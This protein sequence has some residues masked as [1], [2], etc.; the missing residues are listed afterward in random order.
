MSIKRF[1][2]V[3]LS[4]LLIAASFGAMGCA[5]KEEPQSGIFYLYYKDVSALNLH[6][7]EAYFDQAY[8]FEE[9]VASI[10]GK[11]RESDRRATYVSA[12]PERVE[13]LSAVLDGTCLVFDFSA[14]YHQML[15]FEEV[16][17]RAAVVRTFTQMPEVSTVEFRVEGQPLVLQRGAGTL[18]GPMKASDFM[19]VFGSGLN[20]Y[21]E[22]RFTLYFATESGDKLHPVVR[23]QYHS[24]QI[25]LEQFALQQLISG[26]M[27]EAEGFPVLPPS[28]KINSL[29]VREGVCH[30]DLSTD[31]L[32]QSLSLP[33]ETIIFSI[34]D[35]LTE[36]TGTTSVRISIDS[37]SDVF[38]MDTVD[39]SRLLYRNLDYIENAAVSAPSE[40]AV[41]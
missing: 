4:V 18:V 26:P 21:T 1:S 10:F 5:K 23:E 6:P 17:M 28:L 34:V 11:L 31:I 32:T 19:D 24:N 40:T 38:F 30:V 13:I 16:M 12:I 2:A 7:V 27:S 35:T 22:G 37:R 8:P 33:A 9:R 15:F 41:P 25:S 36:I 14:S 39:L 29:T 20:A 3:L